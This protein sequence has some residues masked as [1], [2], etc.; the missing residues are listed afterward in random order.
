MQLLLLK[1]AIF[2]KLR[3][4]KTSF[5]NTINY[6][7][8]SKKLPVLLHLNILMII[9]FSNISSFLIKINHDSF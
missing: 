2:F 6:T 9:D 8:S 1:T 7:E 3:S 5:K 4:N